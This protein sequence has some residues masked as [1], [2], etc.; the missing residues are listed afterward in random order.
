MHSH[1]LTRDFV[2]FLWLEPLHPSYPMTINKI[3]GLDK[4]WMDIV[5][6]VFLPLTHLFAPSYPFR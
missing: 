6:P 5:S 2:F 4:G 3:S 1:T